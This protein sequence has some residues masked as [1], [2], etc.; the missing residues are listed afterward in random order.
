MLNIS[1]VPE[2][3]RLDL[4]IAGNYNIEDVYSDSF[5]EGVGE[6]VTVMHRQTDLLLQ[7]THTAFSRV[8]VVACNSHSILPDS[9]GWKVLR[10]YPGAM[11]RLIR[12]NRDRRSDISRVVRL[13]SC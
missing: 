10:I 6:S 8:A 4:Y 3:L 5:S 11:A 1:I 12:N 7:K 2:T 13:F 9:A